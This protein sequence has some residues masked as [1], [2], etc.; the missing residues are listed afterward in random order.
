MFVC[1]A[2]AS[3]PPA[4]A[5]TIHVFE[6]LDAH[7]YPLPGNAI[8]LISSRNLDTD[9]HTQPVISTGSF[10]QPK[11]KTLARSYNKVAFISMCFP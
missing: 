11:K 2:L 1:W 5:F 10:V 9:T 6:L 3:L 7:T 4:A 8:E